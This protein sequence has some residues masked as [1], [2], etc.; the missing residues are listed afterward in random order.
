MKYEFIEF[1][2]GLVVTNEDRDVI[3]MLTKQEPKRGKVPEGAYFIA[4]R[5]WVPVAVRAEV[6]VMAHQGGAA[7]GCTYLLNKK[8]FDK[9][10]TAQ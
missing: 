7:P 2:I 9:M 5:D 4:F 10:S 1:D 8:E 6:E 3:A